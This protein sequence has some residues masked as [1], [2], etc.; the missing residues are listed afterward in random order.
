MSVRHRGPGC[1]KI[2]AL[3]TLRAMEIPVDRYVTFENDCLLP[4]ECVAK[5]FQPLAAAYWEFNKTSCQKLLATLRGMH[6]QETEPFAD[7]LVAPEEWGASASILFFFVSNNLDLFLFELFRK[8][9]RGSYHRGPQQEPPR[10][11]CFPGSD[12]LWKNVGWF[13]RD[14]MIPL[15]SYCCSFKHYPVLFVFTRHVLLE[16]VQE[17]VR[18]V[19]C[20]HKTKALHQRLAIRVFPLFLFH[21]HF[22]FIHFFT[23]GIFFYFYPPVESRI[24][25]WLF[26]FQQSLFLWL[27]LF[28][29]K[30]HLLFLGWEWM[31]N[32]LVNG[33]WIFFLFEEG[34]I[35]APVSREILW[36][37]Y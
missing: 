10:Y 3:E 1:N 6:P 28:P 29:V 25:F 2:D 5:A 14:L 16:I 8:R 19:D 18:N 15:S 32:G 17:E 20:L 37:T 30:F 27:S 23:V 33:A 21:K 4:K 13:S 9:R 12:F 11:F 34:F 31:L 36:T 22:T 26:Y 35:Y 7:V 24:C